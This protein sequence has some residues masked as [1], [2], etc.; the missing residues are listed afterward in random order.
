MRALRRA[1]AITAVNGTRA[2]R[3]PSRIRVCQ[4]SIRV[5]L[6]ILLEASSAATLYASESVG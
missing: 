6:R 2:D 3:M 1:L 4:P 5:M